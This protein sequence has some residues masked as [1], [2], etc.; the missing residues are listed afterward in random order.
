ML[1]SCSTATSADDSWTFPHHHMP[2][3]I[4]RL[5]VDLHEYS[6]TSWL[7]FADHYLHCARHL[8][9]FHFDVSDPCFTRCEVRRHFSSFVHWLFSSHRFRFYDKLRYRHRQTTDLTSVNSS[10]RE[11][12]NSDVAFIKTNNTTTTTTTNGNVSSD[13]CASFSSV[14][15]ASSLLHDRCIHY[16]RQEKISVNCCQVG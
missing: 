12:N 7:I 5:L 1:S 9:R 15:I 14:R 11:A 16:I 4:I 6:L 3:V 2:P 8:D 13:G 10:I